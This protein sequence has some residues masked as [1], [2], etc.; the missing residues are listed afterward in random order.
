[1]E[2]FLSLK[3]LRILSSE[4]FKHGK[5]HN[6]PVGEKNGIIFRDVYTYVSV[7]LLQGRYLSRKL[8][9]LW[10]KPV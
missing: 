8:K 7:I 9:K 1:M 5:C 3:L 6:H 4:C 10:Q 2:N